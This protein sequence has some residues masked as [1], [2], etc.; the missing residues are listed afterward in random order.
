MNEL[1]R[2][3]M[4]RPADLPAP[5]A[6][7]VLAPRKIDTGST[8]AVARRQAVELLRAGPDVVRVEDLAHVEVALAVH[9]ALTEAPQTLADVRTLVGTFTP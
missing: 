9:A 5:D 2:F 7:Q 1:F 3:L 4:L 6:V 8:K